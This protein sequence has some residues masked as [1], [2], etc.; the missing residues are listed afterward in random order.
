MLRIADAVWCFAFDSEHVYSGGRD[1]RVIKWNMN[2]KCIQHHHRHK[3][4]V[5]AIHYN[6][7]TSGL[8]SVSGDRTVWKWDFIEFKGEGHRSAVQRIASARVILSHLSFH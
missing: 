6:P 7:V 4:L 3:D 1:G 2:G 8:F 5:Y